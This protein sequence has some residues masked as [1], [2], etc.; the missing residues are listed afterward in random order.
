MKELPRHLKYAFLE[1]KKEN[2]IIISAALIELEEQKLLEIIRKNKEAIAWSIEYLKGIRPSIC[3]HK[4]LLEDNAKTFVE[5]QRRLNPVIKE[6]VR[7]EVL[8]WLNAGFIYAIL[9]N[10]WV[11]PVHVVPKNGGFTMIKNEKN[12]SMPTKT[13]TVWRVC[14]YRLQKTK[15]CYYKGSL[16]S[17]F[18]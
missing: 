7:K 14:I 5:H 15:H 11:N 3:M 12:E 13:V 4:I 9:D 10:H 18:H 6:V 1:P 17:T 2:P 16:S 8:E